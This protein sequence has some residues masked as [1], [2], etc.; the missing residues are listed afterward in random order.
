LSKLPSIAESAAP[1]I[2][3]IPT[4]PIIPIGFQYPATAAAPAIDPLAAVLLAFI[5]CSLAA[6]SLCITASFAVF[7]SNKPSSTT[8]EAAFATIEPEDQ[9]LYPVVDTILS[10]HPPPQYF[11][12]LN[13]PP[14]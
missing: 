8:G 9:G 4:S 14:S 10:N 7:K 3:L 2:A 6:A 12:G 1:L 11:L 13:I 5:S